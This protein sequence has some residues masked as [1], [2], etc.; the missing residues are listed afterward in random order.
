M[1]DSNPGIELMRRVKAGFIVQGTT[2]TEWC[3]KNDTHVS[4]VRNALYGTWN[5]P[6]GRAM[7]QRVVKA[8]RVVNA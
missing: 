7:R 1:T 2:L 8:A 5:G 4:N 3:R 6:K